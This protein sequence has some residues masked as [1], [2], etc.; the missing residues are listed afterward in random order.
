[1]GK[2][3][4]KQ[5]ND[6]VGANAPGETHRRVQ[7]RPPLRLRAIVGVTGLMLSGPL[8]A[9]S[10][11]YILNYRGADGGCCFNNNGSD[12]QPATQDVEQTVSGLNIR[13]T[14]STAIFVD[15]SG[16]NG[17]NS[18]DLSSMSHWGGNGGYGRIADFVVRSS[19]V[20]STEQG[21]A[22]LSKGG[23]GGLYG[24]RSNGYGSGADGHFARL[25][26]DNTRVTANGDG[27]AARSIGGNGQRSAIPQ[28]PDANNERDAGNGGNA[29]QASVIMQG[30][31][32][33]SVVGTNGA[34]VIAESL[35]GQG[36]F[37]DNESEWGGHAY[38]G[39]G[40]SADAA[41]VTVSD[42][43]MTS[44]GQGMGG[45]LARS[46]GGNGPKGVGSN[47][48]AADGGNA[49]NV[50][51]QNGAAITTSGNNAIGIAAYSIG[52]NGGDGGSGSWSFGHDGGA[53]GT[54][55][56]INIQNDGA[57]TT[58][59]L[60]SM[61]I[62]A[63]VVGGTGG[64]GGEAGASGSGGSGGAGGA[65][66][67]LA[68]YVANASDAAIRTSGNS[69]P[70]MVAHAVGGG[71]GNASASS[72]EMVI[73]GG[74]GGSGGEGGNLHG[75]NSGVIATTG[76]QSGG[77]LVQSVGGGGGY[78]G[79]ANAVGVIFSVATG[80][81]GGPGGGGGHVSIEQM[82]DISTTG[83][84]SSGI[85]VQSIG[86]GGG[87]GGSST[88]A[89]VG[90][91]LGLAV[92]HGGAGGGGG[93][94]GEVYATLYD[95][96][97]VTTSGVMSSG[98]VAQSLGGGGGNGGFASSSQIT[99]APDLGPG[100]W[101]ATVSPH[102][103]IGGSGGSGGNGGTVGV[104]TANLITTHGAKSY[105]VLAQS[106]GGGGGNGGNAAAPLRTTS[107]PS[108]NTRFNISVG[109]TIGGT[110]GNGGN[111]DAVTV[112]NEGAG[113]I[114]T[115]GD[116][117]VAVLAQS[118]GGGGGAGG[119][120]QQ[121]TAQSFN[122]TLGGPSN[123]LGL[124]KQ[125]SDWL[126]S[127][128]PKPSIAFGS[129]TLGVDVRVGGGGASGGNG[130]AVSVVNNGTVG[131]SG[132]A[133]AAIVA[134]SVGGG[135]G[136]GGTATSTSVSS[137][138]SSIDALYGTVTGK[139]ANYF[140]VSP[141]VGSNVA[142]GGNGGSGGNGGAVSVTNTHHL[143]TQGYAAPAIVA[144]SIG[145]G[146]GAGVSTT[147]SLDV[148]LHNWA[149]KEAPAILGEINRIVDLLG[150]NLAS[151]QHNVNVSVGSKGGTDGDGGA[152]TVNAGDSRSDIRTQGDSAPAILAQSVASGGGYAAA[153]NYT[154]GPSSFSA[155][156]GPALSLNLGAEF[157]FSTTHTGTPGTVQV[158]NGGDIGTQGND[159]TGILAQ[160]VSGGGGTATLGLTAGTS[161]TLAKD[162]TRTQP[163]IQLGSTLTNG[164]GTLQASGG[165][166]TVLNTGTIAT[167]GVLSHGILAQS[168]SGGGGAGSLTTSALAGT[169]I[170]GPAVTLGAVASSGDGIRADAGNVNVNVGDGKTLV[171]QI[172]SSI[173]TNGALSFG[174]LAQS[175]GGGGGYLALTSG[176]A[177]MSL[178]LSDLTLGATG[179]AGGK[180]G[181]VTT[182]L[183]G[184]ALIRTSGQ[185]A[186]GIVAQSVGGGGGIAGLTTAPG[187]VS[188]NTASNTAG[189]ANVNDG[190]AVNV[191]VI[192]QVQTS[193]NGAAGVLAQS[194]GN[195]GGIAGDLS[196]LN[197]GNVPVTYASVTTNAGSGAGGNVDVYVGGRIN[198]TG[199]NAPGILAM[200]LGGGGVLS[201]SGILIKSAAYRQG[202]A[203]GAV[204]VGLIQGASVSA[205]GEGSPA[206]AAFSLGSGDSNGGHPDASPMT[207]SVA[208]G[209][210]VAA[211]A[212]SGIGVLA[213][214]TGTVSID[215][216]GSVTAKTA[217]KTL[218][219][220]VVNNT[221]LVQGDVQ[222]GSGSVF[223]NH[224]GGE[225]RSG[226][227]LTVDTL[228]N[229][230]V[231]SPGG[232][233]SYITTVL[234]GSLQETGTYAPDV[235]FT[236]GRSD[237][238]SVTGASSY[239]GNVVP[240]LHN[241]VKDIWLNIAHFDTV[242][243]TSTTTVLSPA[244][245][246][247][248]RSKDAKGGTS[249]PMVAVDANFRP[250]GVPLN[251][252]QSS[253][254]DY[255]QNLWQ[256][257]RLDA[258]P[259]FQPLVSATNASLYKKTL[260]TMAASASLMRAGSRGNES[261][262]FLNRLMSCPQFVNA[263]TR[264]TEG[265]CVWGRVIGTRSDRY[266]TADDSGFRSQQLTWQ[267]G[268]QKEF[269]PDWFVGGS[270]SY[271]V[272]HA[273]SSDQS[274][275]VS[276][277][278]FRGG[279]TLKHQM[280]PWQVALAVLGGF[281]S[282]TQNRT[283][284]YPEAF[285]VATSRP[286]AYFVGARTRL[287]YQLNY[288]GWY[289][290][291]YA[292]VDVIYDRTGAYRESGGGVFDLAVAAQ[293]RT[294]VLV[295]PTIEVGGRFDWHGVTVRPY[296]SLGASFTSKGNA[297]VDAQLVQ[298]PT[299]PFQITSSQPTVYGNLTAGVELLSAK[300]LE[301][302]AEYS[303]RRAEAQTVQSAALRLAK[304]F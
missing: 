210:S 12:G 258:G 193:G 160:S 138:M 8:F 143:Y 199:A 269:V 56:S 272:T 288:A 202:N 233:R 183:G 198:T 38:S 63:S 244:I 117:S 271:V 43:T 176:N 190:G 123:A 219:R 127:S 78:G 248:F 229:A 85:L 159:S 113:S 223:N 154:F 9:Q 41:I 95:E 34:A 235:D 77:M 166:V 167:G 263:G 39:R 221:G 80:G 149:P 276:S 108:E 84:D 104:D 55:G 69:A 290:K 33:V 211:N 187:Q 184:N 103:T 296:L 287:S 29:G 195:G 238:L 65:T 270:A 58:R 86:G 93:N 101:T 150:S 279:L 36:G 216:A 136:N 81:R 152:V 13:A 50:T 173:S 180:G 278:G 281:E 18:S 240:I 186:H 28:F 24:Y 10:G 299:A 132:D 204:S 42:G 60:G 300:G 59:G 254:A 74:T 131:T 97:T 208:N 161:T 124:L 87:A 49:G 98:L 134:Q 178:S 243:S 111:G 260:D 294:S 92:S 147:Q 116:H 112:T 163:S 175:V 232:P 54:P 48:R 139:V 192:G 67:A 53:G 109:V 203:G 25:T 181:A 68:V 289:V 17:G 220:T 19:T 130:A 64:S 165:S 88:S 256:L 126:S 76:D 174:V 44:D 228:N 66:G 231:L 241:P 3:W 282:G 274:L 177:A 225:L 251:T 171:N 293:G 261:Y 70:G 61:G 71:G 197:F 218:S 2:A 283:I 133:A 257:G 295:S 83:A 119:T 239:D 118:I 259:L 292:D 22:V 30:N 201:D 303:L 252:N 102:V 194:V 156:S 250:Q 146:G 164:I 222:L 301:L 106:V 209:A 273:H 275:Q 268:A 284:D 107:I 196:S 227:V 45:I 302:R 200:S 94:G 237:L 105:G 172:A 246:F 99:I 20:A 90:V 27:I 179:G 140:Q 7:H 46:V 162:A 262:D 14:G 82:G 52:G 51:V 169:L 47:V 266:D 72:G 37:G 57:I 285:A 189:G 280:G 151:A 286:D 298:F 1:M 110:G 217:I 255:L 120:V 264:M 242:P 213:V 224:I 245:A 23:D 73:G 249:D 100:V 11:P 153:S 137:L 170:D 207:I 79:D 168:V 155:T 226:A 158:T 267:F 115:S 135:G 247:S 304:H 62:F 129:L 141:N 191:N 121:E 205:M 277:D 185:D 114:V 265:S 297:S 91:G 142:V 40:G 128:T 21:I 212:T 35:G 125:I 215:N 157:G 31:S 206:I 234:T 188:L 122:A 214:N 291:P 6:T 182:T 253:F 26:I 236:N 16:G 144:Q 32:S 96:S 5:K 89:A 15:V 145:G 230:G 75:L 148:L 4:G